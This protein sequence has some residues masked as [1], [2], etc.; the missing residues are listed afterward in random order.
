M[1]N[2]HGMYLVAHEP[3]ESTEAAIRNES[4]IFSDS[5]LVETAQKRINVADT[6][7]GEEIRESIKQLEDLLQA[8]QNGILVEKDI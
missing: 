4:D 3:F 8:Y 6:D 5:I 1:Y 7:K 2:S